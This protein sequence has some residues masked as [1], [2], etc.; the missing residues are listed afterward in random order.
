VRCAKHLGLGGNFQLRQLTR[1]NEN[2]PGNRLAT[3]S[4][5]PAMSNTCERK[6]Q[7]ACSNTSTATTRSP[8][9]EPNIAC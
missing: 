8:K 6:K 3:I 2:Y 9:G 4:V 5:G 7:Q 1:G